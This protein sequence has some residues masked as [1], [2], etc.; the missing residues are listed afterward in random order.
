[1]K[2]IKIKNM[3]FY[4]YHGVFEEEKKLGQEFQVDVIIEMPFIKKIQNDTL[5][6]T[7]DYS[8]IYNVTKKIVE[9][10]SYNLIEALAETILNELYNVFENES[11][12]ISSITVTIRKPSAPIEGI[13]DYAEIEVK[14]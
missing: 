5:D 13:F 11:T 2:K 9:G 8:K 6:N 4:A 3:R 14:G 1:M 7:L 12:S 10:N